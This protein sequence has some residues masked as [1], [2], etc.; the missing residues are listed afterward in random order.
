MHG[1]CRLAADYLVVQKTVNS[2]A[3]FAVDCSVPRELVCDHLN[4][5]KVKQKV[6]NIEVLN[7]VSP[8]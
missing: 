5:S 8:C 4:W 3:H 1:H 7:Q 6:H 2:H